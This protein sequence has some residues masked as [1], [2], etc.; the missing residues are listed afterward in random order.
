VAVNWSEME[1]NAYGQ[2]CC[3]CGEPI[4]DYGHNPEPLRPW[5]QRCCQVCNDTAV[6]LVRLRG[7][8]RSAA[9]FAALEAIAAG[10]WDRFLLR[11]RAAIEQRRQ[12]DEYKAHIVARSEVPKQGKKGGR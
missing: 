1:G 7:P 8:Q 9:A 11:L 12:T 2:P 10:E 6:I 4:D 3:L 5:P